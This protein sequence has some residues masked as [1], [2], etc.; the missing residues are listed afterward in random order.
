MDKIYKNIKTIVNNG[1]KNVNGY[2]HYN[3][4]LFISILDHIN[5]TNNNPNKYNLTENT[6]N[7]F[8]IYL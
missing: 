8:F 1:H 6:V 5:L 3:A 2:N 7:H 4:C